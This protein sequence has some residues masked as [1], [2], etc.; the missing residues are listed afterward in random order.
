MSAVD[1]CSTLVNAAAASRL[2]SEPTTAVT[3]L[4]AAS[5]EE[6]G[7]TRPIR[8]IETV[9]IPI[10][11]HSPGREVISMVGARRARN[12]EIGAVAIGN[13]LMQYAGREFAATHGT[14]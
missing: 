7:G 2:M 14:L 8:K 10:T 11:G 13:S 1:S 12:R 5:M 4:C 6:T 9:R 3:G